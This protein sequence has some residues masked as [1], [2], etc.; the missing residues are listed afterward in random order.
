MGVLSKFGRKDDDD[1]VDLN[2]LNRKSGYGPASSDYSSDDISGL[3][4]PK[5]VG[6]ADTELIKKD[7]EI[8]KSRFEMLKAEIDEIRHRIMNL[9]AQKQQR[10]ESN[11]MERYGTTAGIQTQQPAQQET[12]WH[13]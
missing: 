7:I 13:Y 5:P 6:S 12:G 10:V 1:F 2:T 9:E 3:N 8:L 4:P 11:Q